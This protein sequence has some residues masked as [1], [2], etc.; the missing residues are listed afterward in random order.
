[1]RLLLARKRRSVRSELKSVRGVVGHK[2]HWRFLGPSHEA[3]C[4]ISYIC[5]FWRDYCTTA[6]SARLSSIYYVTRLASEWLG[7]V[8]ELH[9]LCEWFTLLVVSCQLDG[10]KV[11]CQL[12][13]QAIQVVNLWSLEFARFFF[14]FSS[15]P[16]VQ[17]LRFVCGAKW[18]LT[19]RL[20]TAGWNW[21]ICEGFLRSH[22]YHLHKWLLLQVSSDSKWL[23]LNADDRRANKL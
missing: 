23:N 11:S 10:A 4:L 16:Q 6:F 14:F 2:G 22:H 7:F 13:R 8:A 1:M 15:T 21:L 18:W 9:A 12:K 3:L 20:G 5:W 19:I 17:S